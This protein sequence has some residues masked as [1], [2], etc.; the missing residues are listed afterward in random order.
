MV[1]SYGPFSKSDAGLNLLEIAVDRV[2]VRASPCCLS[3]GFREG[4]QH[5]LGTDLIPLTHS[6]IPPWELCRVFRWFGTR[7]EARP[8]PQSVGY[9]GSYIS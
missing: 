7:S 9:R 8:L 3:K 1:S 4:R 6:V 5:D 2:D